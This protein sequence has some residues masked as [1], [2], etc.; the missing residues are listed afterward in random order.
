MPSPLPYKKIFHFL[1]ILF[2]MSLFGGEITL[3]PSKWTKSFPK[4][5]QA[6]QK[7]RF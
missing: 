3:P 6:T 2:S 5:Y 4:Q 7:K 1:D